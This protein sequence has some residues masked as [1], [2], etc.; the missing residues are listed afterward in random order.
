MTDAATILIVDD[1][2]DARWALSTF[3]RK[4]GFVPLLAESGRDALEALSTQ[5][6]DAVLLDVW[7]T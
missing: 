5:K 4:I 2:E 1:M 6:V 3:I 7:A